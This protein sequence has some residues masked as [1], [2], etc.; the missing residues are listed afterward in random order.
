MNT[1]TLPQI[2]SFAAPT[3]ADI[4]AWEKLDDDERRQMIFAE[5]EKAVNAPARHVTPDDIIKGARKRMNN[6]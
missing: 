3:D 4:E 1:K 2:S 5:L 6:G